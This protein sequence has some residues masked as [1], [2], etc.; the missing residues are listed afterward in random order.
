LSLQ[1]IFALFG[2]FRLPQRGSAQA[3]TRF[4]RAFAGSSGRFVKIGQANLGV[5]R[6]SVSQTLIRTHWLARNRLSH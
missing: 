6:K 5:G 1:A 2:R 4:L 3:E